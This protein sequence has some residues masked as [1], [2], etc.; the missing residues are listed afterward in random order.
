MILQVIPD[1][2]LPYEEKE[3][4]IEGEI[5]LPRKARVAQESLYPSTTSYGL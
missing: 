3:E 4:S 1:L 2:N 5:V